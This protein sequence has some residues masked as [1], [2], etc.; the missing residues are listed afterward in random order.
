MKK[1]V[2]LILVLV[3]VLSIAACNGDPTP[4]EGNKPAETPAETPIETPAE[5]P[6]ETPEETPAETDPIDEAKLDSPIDLMGIKVVIPAAADRTV[7]Y[8]SDAFINGVRMITGVS[9]ELSAGAEQEIEILIGNT[10]RS[11]S[12]SLKATLADGE[13]A[14]KLVGKKLVVAASE[15]GFLYEAVKTL[16]GFLKIEDN[17]ETGESKLTLKRSIDVKQAGDK[18]SFVYAFSKSDTVIAK[19]TLFTTITAA[20]SDVRGTQGGTT[21]G[22]YLYQAFVKTVGNETNNE[23]IIVKYDMETKRTV[24]MSE[25]L[26]LNHCNDL[27]YDFNTNRIIAVHQSINPTKLSIL[28]ADTLQYVET[29]GYMQTFGMSHSPERQQFACGVAGGLNIK[30]QPDTLKFDPKGILIYA[31][32][33]K[34]DGYISQGIGCDEN[35]VYSVLWDGRNKGKPTFQNIIAVYDWYGNRVGII[36]FNVGVIEPEN[37]S[38]ID[39]VLY[40]TFSTSTGAKVFKMVAEVK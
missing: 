13:F 5:T 26:K 16:L 15:D 12:E 38:S 33:A 4:T 32:P 30:L 36:K 34:T 3:T 39:G 20:A 9:P 8:A 18:S 24:A 40:V 29:I 1:F 25:R 22:K 7:N 2:S 6:E 31:D 21:D 19:E 17:A 27:M 14:V 11:E 23:V 28:D 10:G 35:F 37:I